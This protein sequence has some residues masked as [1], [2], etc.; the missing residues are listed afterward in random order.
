MLY[1]DERTGFVEKITR[2]EPNYMMYGEVDKLTVGI[3][4]AFCGLPA[5]IFVL[6]APGNT[7][8]GL[9]LGE[10]RVSCGTFHPRNQDYV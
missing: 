8:C 10:K 6:W 4:T 7:F 1:N 2:I 9:H 5:S 3:Q